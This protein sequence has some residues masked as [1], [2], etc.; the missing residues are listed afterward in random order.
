MEDNKEDVFVKFIVL[1]CEVNTRSTN[2]SF[3]LVL[4]FVMLKQFYRFPPP[5]GD[6]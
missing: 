4:E 5:I 6:I 2:N 3:V 1:Y